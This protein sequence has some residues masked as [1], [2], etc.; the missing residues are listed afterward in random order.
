MRNHRLSAASFAAATMFLP[1]TCESQQAQPPQAA[2]VRGDLQALGAVLDRA[3]AQVSR[4]SG[5]LIMGGASS[6]GY[7]LAGLGAVFVLPPRALPPDRQVFVMRRRGAAGEAVME[8]LVKDAQD[9]MERTFD[10]LR[11]AEQERVRQEQR[12]AEG[13]AREAKLRSEAGRRRDAQAL[14]RELREIENEVE[15]FQREAEAARQDAERALEEV[16]RAIR[17]RLAEEVTQPPQA[18]APPAAS[19]PA[20]PVAPIAPEPGTPPMPPTPPWHNWF[21]SGSEAEARTPQQVILAVRAAVTQALESHGARL[22]SVRPD[23]S[24]IVAVDFVPRAFLGPGGPERTLVVRARKKDLD[25]RS[26]GHISADE[27]R[28]RI[29]YLEY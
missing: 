26:T 20:A 23:E 9:E 1:L 12:R 16:T 4:A 29:E 22:R 5:A 17:I 2:A 7:R 18:V 11:R 13:E 6:R 3:V 28:K 19:A 27:L 10:T 24:V 8:R 25:E 15:A 14:D 21:E